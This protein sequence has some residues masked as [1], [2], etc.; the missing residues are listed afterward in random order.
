MHAFFALKSIPHV[1]YEKKK[2]KKKRFGN[3]SFLTFF[4]TLDLLWPRFCPK[5]SLTLIFLLVSN[6]IC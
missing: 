1:K 2:Q 3:A 5:T 4:T 6:E